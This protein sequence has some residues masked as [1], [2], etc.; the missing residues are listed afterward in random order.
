MCAHAYAYT[1]KHMHVHLLTYLYTYTNILYLKTDVSF[2][3]KR[4]TYKKPDAGPKVQVPDKS[5][6]PSWV[7]M[8]TPSRDGGWVRVLSIKPNC[9]LYKCEGRL[10]KLSKPGSQKPDPVRK[11]VTPAG[12]TWVSHVQVEGTLK[13]LVAV[14]CK[15]IVWNSGP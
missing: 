4:Q 3:R 8:T 10:N 5:C 11:L 1:H 12:L 6:G 15:N 9:R 13:S 7:L 14:S 2:R